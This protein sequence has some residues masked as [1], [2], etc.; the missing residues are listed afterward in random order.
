MLRRMYLKWFDKRNFRYEMISEHKG[1]EAGIKSSILRIVG[2]NLYGLMKK[3]SE[4]ID[5]LEFLLSTLV[6][7]G[8]Q[9]L[10]VFGFILV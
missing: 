2:E 10:Q 7:E 6:L 1:D 5:W 9:V 8:T 3:E 4:Y